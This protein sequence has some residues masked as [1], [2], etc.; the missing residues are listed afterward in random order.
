MSMPTTL[1]PVILSGGS[2][3]RLW[4]MSRAMYPKQLLSM[5]S[6]QTLAKV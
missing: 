6:E 2:G 4:P 1:Q 5:V 3:S